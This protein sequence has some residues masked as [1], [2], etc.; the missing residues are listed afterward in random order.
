MS[1][2][3][4]LHI[5]AVTPRLSFSAP[6]LHHEVADS[7]SDQQRLVFSSLSLIYC[8]LRTL[9]YVVGFPVLR[10]VP[11]QPH[12][13][14]LSARLQ[15]FSPPLLQLFCS[16]RGLPFL[17]LAIQPSPW[18]FVLLV[19]RFPERMLRESHLSCPL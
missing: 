9:R 14:S 16:R 12:P 4:A 18:I 11:E 10:G 17:L 13:A 6:Q 5:H 19:S 3:L 8:F 15:I 2:F 7:S 1:S